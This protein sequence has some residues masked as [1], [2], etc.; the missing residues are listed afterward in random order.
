MFLTQIINGQVT[1]L[2]LCEACARAKGLFDPQSLTFAEKFFP[3]ELKERMD[4]IMQELANAKETPSG[5]LASPPSPDVLTQCPVCH[6]SLEDFRRTGRL[7]CPDCYT[8]FAS[9]LETRNNTPS[10][11]APPC[12]GDGAS[13]ALQ[14][15]QLEQQLRNAIDKE[16]YET[17]ALLRDKLKTLD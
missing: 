12:S 5:N 4:K 7:G 8:V 11:A 10:E 17:A 14:R 6:F 13:P 2:A 9:E 15:T 1:E 16:D 3:E